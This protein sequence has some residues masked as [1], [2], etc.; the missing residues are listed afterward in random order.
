MQEGRKYVN[1]NLT[2]K[3]MCVL[4]VHTPEEAYKKARNLPSVFFFQAPRDFVTVCAIPRDVRL[5]SSL[6]C[7]KELTHIQMH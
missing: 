7:A 6:V 1:D 5:V 2:S 4:I 3:G